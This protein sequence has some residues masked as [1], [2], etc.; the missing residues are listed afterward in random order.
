[1][2]NDRYEHTQY[3][4]RRKVFQLFGASFHVYDPEGMVVL[5]SKQKA[6]K[7][8]EDIRVFASETM[9]DELL[10]IQARQIVD[11]S[12]AYDVI[13]ST[14][15][16]KLG[17]LR[18][19]GWSSMMRDSWEILDPADAPIGRIQED[20][21]AMALVRRFLSN[22][23]PQS[24]NVKVNGQRVARFSQNFNPFVQ[25]LKLDFSLD[26]DGQLDRRLG[27]AAAVLIVAIEGRQQ[28]N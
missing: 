20:S 9:A 7:L 4:V 27:L 18:R 16:E 12:A 8:R 22:L 3:L 1:M 19:K 11:F 5:Y 24:Y 15:G 17:A 28:G 2:F 21:M 6:F 25:K 14:T 13:D 26:A 23:I 10:S